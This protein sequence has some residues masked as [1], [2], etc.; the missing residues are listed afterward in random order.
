MYL[1]ACAYISVAEQTDSNLFEEHELFSATISCYTHYTGY[2]HSGD[3]ASNN[4][5]IIVRLYLQ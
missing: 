2:F 5:R 3:I 1:V 4:T